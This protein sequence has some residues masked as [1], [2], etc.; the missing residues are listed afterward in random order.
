[1]SWRERR[2]LPALTAAL[3]DL[4]IS[5]VPTSDHRTVFAKNETDLLPSEVH[6]DLC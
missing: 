1:M 3:F 6:L 4:Q 2:E 5:R